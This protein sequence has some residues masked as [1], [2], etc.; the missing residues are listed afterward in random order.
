MLAFTAQHH[1]SNFPFA[2][3]YALLEIMPRKISFGYGLYFCHIFVDRHNSVLRLY[4]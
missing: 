3:R 1:L 4:L 2:I